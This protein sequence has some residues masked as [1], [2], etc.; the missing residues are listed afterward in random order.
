MILRKKKKIK[1]VKIYYIKKILTSKKKKFK[2]IQ[3]TKHLF[4]LIKI[5]KIRK[6]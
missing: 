4:N 6:K 2:I 5:R 1:Q 3:K